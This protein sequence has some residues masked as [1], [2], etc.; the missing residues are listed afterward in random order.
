MQIQVET[1]RNIQGSEA[2]IDHVTGVVK[3]ALRRHSDH[4]TQVTV[5][6]SDEN[7]D[8]KGG[9]EDI[10]CLIEATI[11]GFPPTVVSHKAATWQQAVNGGAGQLARLLTNNAG[12]RSQLGRHRTD[13]PL[14]EAVFKEQA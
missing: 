13:P 10:L 7:S 2:L 9:N 3:S 5:H 1:D 14:A 4:V 6:L 12:R 11:E 8:K